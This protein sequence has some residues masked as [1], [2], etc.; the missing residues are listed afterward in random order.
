MYIIDSLTLEKYLT[1]LSITAMKRFHSQNGFEHWRLKG[2]KPTC[3]VYVY[4]GNQP[5]MTT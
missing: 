1:D 3:F 2:I 5:R 4:S